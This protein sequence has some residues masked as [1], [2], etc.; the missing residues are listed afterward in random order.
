MSLV[1]HH[2]GRT[3]YILAM[4]PVPPLPPDEPKPPFPDPE[5]TP[6]IPEPEPVRPIPEPL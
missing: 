1:D 5:P 4:T 3:G 2:L 6:P